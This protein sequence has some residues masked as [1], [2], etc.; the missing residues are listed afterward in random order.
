L[1]S[2][3]DPTDLVEISDESRQKTLRTMRID[4]AHSMLVHDHFTKA[5]STFTIS[6]KNICI[7]ELTLERSNCDSNDVLSLV[8]CD[9]SMVRNQS[10]SE[11][12]LKYKDPENK[13]TVK[14]F[15]HHKW[16]QIVLGDETHRNVNKIIAV[17][18]FNYLLDVL[19]S[20]NVT[21]SPAQMIASMTIC[22]SMSI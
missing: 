19:W 20:T 13:T 1:D 8:D 6:R 17:T 22:L 15:Q 10:L 9:R 14:H 21:I 12:N 3:A 7:V 2:A 18:N 5:K 16:K 4:V 11:L